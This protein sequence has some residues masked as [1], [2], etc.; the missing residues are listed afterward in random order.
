VYFIGRDQCL[1]G[2][3][4]EAQCTNINWPVFTKRIVVG[5]PAKLV[6]AHGTPS[7]VQSDGTVDNYLRDTTARAQGFIALMPTMGPGMDA[8]LVESYF[9]SPGLRLDGGNTGVYSRSI[10]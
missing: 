5:D 3:V 8:Y 9:L 4:P 7:S 2:G 1:A 6:S 10:F